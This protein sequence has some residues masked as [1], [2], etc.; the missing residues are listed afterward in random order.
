MNILASLFGKS[1]RQAKPRPRADALAAQSRL[2]VSPVSRQA[3]ASPGETRRE[4]LRVVL[5]ETLRRQGIPQEWI[6]A[7]M[8]A[9]TSRSGESGI[10]WRLSI[11]HWDERLPVHCVGLQNALM[12]RVQTFDPM[13]EQW[14]MGVTWQFALAD[15]SA[16]PPL[17]HASTWTEAQRAAPAQRTAGDVI[18]GPVKIDGTPPEV[19]ADL[20]LL[21][22][23]FDEHY[24][25]NVRPGESGSHYAQ[26]QPASL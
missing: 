19:K 2:H 13:A 12:Q 15:D 21:M 4:L 16:C 25:A 7:D 5:R 14:L 11:R 8:L 9:A 23:A 6:T 26:T 3:V 18:A 20:E 10:H 17:P 22:A 1:A 24:A